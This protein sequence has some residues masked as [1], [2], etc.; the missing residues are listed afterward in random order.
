M[1]RR[2]PL[3]GTIKV[4]SAQAGDAGTTTGI[5]VVAA[6]A[7]K[8]PH[9]HGVMLS[10]NTAGGYSIRIGAT[11]M[12]RLYLATS[13]EVYYPLY[14]FYWANNAVNESINVVKPLAATTNVT[15]FYTLEPPI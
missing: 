9:I 6:D 2:I 7:A 3:A 15:V 10:T 13:S 8:I 1:A 5:T 14:P 12:A 4:L 11:V